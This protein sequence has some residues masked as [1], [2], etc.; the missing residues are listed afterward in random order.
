MTRSRKTI[1]RNRAGR[2]MS[3]PRI[4]TGRRL[5]LGGLL[6]ASGLP[7]I[8]GAGPV[9][10]QGAG[11]A[12]SRRLRLLVHFVPN[13]FYM[14][15]MAAAPGV[16]GWELPPLLSAMQPLKHKVTYLQGFQNAPAGDRS[17]H[18]GQ[19]A[20]LLTGVSPASGDVLRAGVSIDRLI[21]ARAGLTTTLHLATEPPYT[22]CT[23]DDLLSCGYRSSIS[24]AGSAGP[25]P[26]I[27]SPDQALRT[28]FGGATGADPAELASRTRL[29]TDY[30]RDEAETLRAQIGGEDRERLSEFI[31]ATRSVEVSASEYER[32]SACDIPPGV[33]PIQFG[34]EALSDA[35]ADVVELAFRCDATRVVTLM[36]GHGASDRVFGNLGVPEPFHYVSHHDN[37]PYNVAAYETIVH[38]E[39]SRFSRL[40]QRLDAIDDGNGFSVLDNTVALLVSGMG[41]GNDHDVSDMPAL[42]CGATGL[43]PND[44][45]FSLPDGTPLANLHI[46]IAG[47]FG[48]ELDSF[49]RDG[50]GPLQELQV[51]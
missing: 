16:G 26:N 7:L 43:I 29:V 35:M 30:L 45:C 5:F 23:P 27:S 37:D 14:D 46:S 44:A 3:F 49:G 41:D 25:V 12:A 15:G 24:W 21:A 19:T 11:Q 28:L 8:A 9:Y 51:L 10:A 2:T 20:G 48:V 47:L 4:T 17:T 6:S 42:I 50:S 32:L 36:E 18:S 33:D 38:W 1:C 22:F 39:V 40:C 34:V 13:G 31:D